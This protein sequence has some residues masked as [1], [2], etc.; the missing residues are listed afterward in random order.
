M[1]RRKFLKMSA[2]GAA[3]AGAAA[4]LLNSGRL[5]SAAAPLGTKELFA[6]CGA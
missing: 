3:T 5:F 6:K 4:F 2:M 1:N